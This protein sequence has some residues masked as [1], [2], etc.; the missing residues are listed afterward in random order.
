MNS[1]VRHAQASRLLV[2]LDGDD[3]AIGVTVRDNGRPRARP[4]AARP[5]Q[6]RFRPR[7]ENPRHPADTPPCKA[8]SRQCQV[9]NCRA[10]SDG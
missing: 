6:R 9:T 1:A 4:P 8:T 3:H 5:P 10:T 7:R 2:E